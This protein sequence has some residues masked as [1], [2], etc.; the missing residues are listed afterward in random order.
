MNRYTRDLSREK[1][2]PRL[3]GIPA[4]R[5]RFMAHQSDQNL[6][7]GIQLR[8]EYSTLVTLADGHSAAIVS[9][10]EV[11]SLM[12]FSEISFFS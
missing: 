11:T 8:T 10:P 1:S 4:P 3:R 12:V 9:S 7:V 5:F 6:S 2:I